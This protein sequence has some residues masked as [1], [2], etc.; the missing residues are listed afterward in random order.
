MNTKKIEGAATMEISMVKG[1]LP[2][3]AAE[4]AENYGKLYNRYT[5]DGVAFVAPTDS[6][7]ATR[8]GND[9]ALHSVSFNV[10]DDDQLTLTGFITLAKFNS[11]DAL[12]SKIEARKVAV[13]QGNL[14]MLAALN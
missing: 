9:E 6:D 4:G 1:N 12:T 11:Y 3:N 5:V 7:F 2:Y 8:F 14:E 10:N 13:S